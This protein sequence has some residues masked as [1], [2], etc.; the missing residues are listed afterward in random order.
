VPIHRARTR[1]RIGQEWCI[2]TRGNK[3]GRREGGDSLDLV[4]R[5]GGGVFIRVLD[6]PFERL[7]D[8]IPIFC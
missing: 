3:G 1:R 7:V 5:S 4:N 6:E 8:V 2:D